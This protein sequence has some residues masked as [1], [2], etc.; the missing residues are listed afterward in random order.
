MYKQTLSDFSCTHIQYI[1]RV[2]VVVCFYLYC[3]HL[4]VLFVDIPLPCLALSLSQNQFYGFS[5][6]SMVNQYN[7]AT[8]WKEQYHTT[9]NIIVSEAQLSYEEC[10]CSNPDL[11]AKIAIHISNEMKNTALWLAIVAGIMEWMLA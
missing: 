5:N 4:L 10:D 3:Y 1:H 11:T 6:V 2:G 7:E 8:Q 9:H